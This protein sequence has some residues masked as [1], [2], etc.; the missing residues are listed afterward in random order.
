MA[1]DRRFL[2]GLLGSGVAST[3]LAQAPAMSRPT[4][5]TFSF[6]G[7][8]GSKLTLASYAGKPILVVNTASQCGYTPQ[9]AGLQQLW[10]RYRDRGLIIIAVPSIHPP[11]LVVSTTQ[12]VALELQEWHTPKWGWL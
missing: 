9:F 7:L 4:A 2:L 8:D 6:D 12:T 3:A 5:Y 1:I 10:G 11:R